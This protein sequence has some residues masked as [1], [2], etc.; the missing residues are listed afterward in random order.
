MPEVVPDKVFSIEIGG[1]TLKLSNSCG[2]H[3]IR[4]IGAL[5]LYDHIIEFSPVGIMIEDEDGP[6]MAEFQ[7]ARR[8]FLGKEVVERVVRHT[9]LHEVYATEL[10]ETIHEDYLNQKSDSLDDSWLR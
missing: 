3:A 9:G 8:W 1:E 2:D 6:K 4:Y 5:S 10:T 7:I